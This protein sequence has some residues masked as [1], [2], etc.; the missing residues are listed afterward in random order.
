MGVASG[1]VSFMELFDHTT[2][3]VKQGGMRRGANMGILNCD[4]PDIERF[5]SA[6]SE[7]GRLSNFNI[8]VCASDAFIEAI[9]KGDLL[10]L[11]NPAVP[12]VRSPKSRREISS[13]K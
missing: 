9:K 12:G 6:K 8:S 11:I 7:E 3:V 4:H 10:A 2:E 13:R 1:P 5:I